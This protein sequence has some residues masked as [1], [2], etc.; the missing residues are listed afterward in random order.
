VRPRAVTFDAAGTLIAPAAPVG[1]TYARIARRFGIAADA[2]AIGARFRLALPSAPPLAFPGAA[3]ETRLDL[4]R[5]WWWGIVRRTLELDGERTEHR[6]CFDALYAHYADARAWTVFADVHPTLDALRHAAIG[7]A[8]VSNFDG[9]LPGI[10]RGLELDRRVDVVVWSTAAGAAKPDPHI[11]AHAAT[12]LGVPITDV[13]H[14]GDELE[15]DVRGAQAAGAAALLL[16]RTNATTGSLRSL[17]GVL[18][19]TVLNNVAGEP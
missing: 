13:L 14:V 18:N 11:F 8:I 7:I 4:E 1:T 2:D 6:A 3:P 19:G 16:D 9:R 15:A 10:L 17:A 12:R 5:T